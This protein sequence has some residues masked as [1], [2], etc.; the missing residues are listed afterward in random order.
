MALT[1]PVTLK[2]TAMAEQLTVNEG[3]DYLKWVAN[4]KR[5]FT[6]VCTLEERNVAGTLQVLVRFEGR[7]R[8]RTFLGASNSY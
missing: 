3:R 6:R 5:P 7:Q 8:I 1:R 4:G 2:H